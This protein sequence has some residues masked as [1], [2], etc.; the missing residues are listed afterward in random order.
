MLKIQSSFEEEE[1]EEP[2][3]EEVDHGNQHNNHDYV[4]K[5]DISLLYRTVRLEKILDWKIDIE[6]FFN[7]ME[8]LENKQVKMV[9]NNLKVMMLSGVVQ[10]KRQRKA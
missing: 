4:V 9:A 3:K 10:R 8:V 1:E 7:V 6:R 5:A 2:Y